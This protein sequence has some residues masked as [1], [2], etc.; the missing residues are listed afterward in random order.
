MIKV[1]LTD[2]DVCVSSIQPVYVCVCVCICV[3]VCVMSVHYDLAFVIPSWLS[4]TVIVSL[5]QT[6]HAL[7][8][9]SDAQSVT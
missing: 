3:C 2:K 7:R 5:G 6:A 1:H 8:M 9:T 4:A